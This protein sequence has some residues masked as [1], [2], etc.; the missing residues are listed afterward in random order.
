MFQLVPVNGNALTAVQANSL[1]DLYYTTFT[2]YD[3]L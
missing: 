1:N 2:V 3:M